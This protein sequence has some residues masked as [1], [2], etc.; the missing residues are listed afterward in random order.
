MPLDISASFKLTINQPTD[1]LLQFEA[2]DIPEQRILSAETR[3]SPSLHTACVPA[4]DDIGQRI[5]V[6]AE[7]AYQVE[8]SARVEIDRMVP[9]LATLAQLD[10]HELPGE[11]VEYLFDSRYCPGSQFLD[12]T[13]ERFGHL[14]G[15]AKVLAMRDWIFQNFR[16]DPG[17]SHAGTTAVDTFHDLR[18]ICRDFAHVLVCFARASTIP[19][20]YVSCY[21]PGVSPPD[22]HA[23][24]E[25]FLADPTVAGG[26]AWHIV[27]ATMMADPAKTAKIGIGRDAADVSFLTVF[28][29]AQFCSST[30][31]V[32]EALAGSSLE[33]D[34]TPSLA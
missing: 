6:R 32:R 1:F 10:P 31:S 2:A 23:V 8:Y 4:Q 30:V 21:A 19:A 13:A 9:D 18:G 17:S 5:W 33:T 12:F 14:T 16:Y 29:D 25:V 24:V 28:G 26:G 34:P 7:G 20:R 11:T 3:L 15:G 22:F 27:D